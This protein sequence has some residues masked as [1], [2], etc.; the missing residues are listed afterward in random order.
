MINQN[1]LI[2]D[3]PLI[4]RDEDGPVFHAPWQAGAFALAVRLSVEGHF[5]WK[6][7]TDIFSVEIR[8]AQEQG[9][10]DLGNTYYEHWVNA[11]GRLCQERHLV[12]QDDMRQRT[13]EWRQAY[14]NTPHG[15][16]IELSAAFVRGPF[17]KKRV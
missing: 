3:L 8:K 5:T 1:Q 10:P 9:D 11:L 6:E 7:W 17:A 13:E 2:H 15:K 4:P 14:L 16:P 12:D